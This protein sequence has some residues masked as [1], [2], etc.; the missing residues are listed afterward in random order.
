MR[1]KYGSISSYVPIDLMVKPDDLKT[2]QNP[3]C[4]RRSPFASYVAIGSARNKN[5]AE[6]VGYFSATMGFVRNLL[7]L[8]QNPKCEQEGKICSYDQYP[9]LQD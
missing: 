7:G 1:P 2:C 9:R 5:E 4:R 6:P 8:S 3:S